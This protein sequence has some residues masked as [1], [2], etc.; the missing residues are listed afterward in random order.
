MGPGNGGNGGGDGGGQNLMILGSK[1]PRQILVKRG[2]ASGGFGFTLRHFI[3][4]PPE[5]VSVKLSVINI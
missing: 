1:S 2:A 3:V 5:E 4:Y